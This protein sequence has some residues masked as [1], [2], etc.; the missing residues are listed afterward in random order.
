MEG[1]VK[2]APCCPRGGRAV[3]VPVNPPVGN[4]VEDAKGETRVVLVSSAREGAGVSG[5][6]ARVAG[7]GDAVCMLSIK[8]LVETSKGC[9][10]GCCGCGSC[11]CWGGCVSCVVLGLVVVTVKDE[12]EEST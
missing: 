4:G 9:C 1:R 12:S 6:G 3:E 11:C 5:G 10:C 7:R 8:K 2:G